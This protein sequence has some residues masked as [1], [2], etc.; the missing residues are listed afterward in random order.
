MAFLLYNGYYYT[1]IKRIG[2]CIMRM[3]FERKRPEEVGIAS[4]N[5]IRFIDELKKEHVNM[6]SFILYRRNSIIAE[7]YYAPYTRDTL[8][9]VFSVTKSFTSVAIGILADEKKIDL[10]DKIIDYFADKTDGIEVHKYIKD[11]TIRDMLMMST[12]HEATTYKKVTHNDYVR[13]F[14]EVEPSH[15]PGTSYAYDTSSSHTLAALVKKIT[16][17]NILEFLKE[18]CLTELGFSDESYGISDPMGITMGGSGIMAKPIDLLIF[19]NLIM[20]G[21]RVKDRQYI[22][23]EYITLATTCKRNTYVRSN[24]DA[25]RYGYGYQF[26]MTKYNGF[27]CYG[28]G[29]QLVLCYPDKELILVTTAD[30]QDSQEKTQ[31]IYDAFYRNIYDKLDVLNISDNISEDSKSGNKSYKELL[32]IIGSLKIEEDDIDSDHEKL[33]LI[34]KKKFVFDDNPAG[35]IKA[36]IDI[37]D[38]N[39]SGSIILDFKNANA[40][41]NNI[42]NANANSYNISNANVSGNNIS[43][44]NA[45]SYSINDDKPSGDDINNHKSSSGNVSNKAN[46]EDKAIRTYRIEFGVKELKESI[47]PYYNMRYLAKILV[48]FKD[49]F[50]IRCHIIDESVCPLYIEVTTNGDNVTFYMKNKDEVFFKEFNGYVS[51]KIH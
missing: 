24:V 25:E 26:F 13:S 16:G 10:D 14:F 46:M 18:K 47:F 39:E 36:Y 35:L 8:H 3:Y 49:T 4:E 21:G 28:M 30:T 15:Y 42:S 7:A 17:K 38:N 40:S 29:G 11:I 33:K 9:R 23:K 37:D 12:A 31:R 19:A 51:G 50:I 1:R 34:D 5:I 32:D 27:C 43:N 22:S 20:N 48:A 45:S 44:A 6:H 2:E 41:G